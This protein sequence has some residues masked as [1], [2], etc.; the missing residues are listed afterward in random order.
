MCAQSYIAMGSSSFIVWLGAPEEHHIGAQWE[1]GL[2]SL[3]IVTREKLKYTFSMNK[4]KLVIHWDANT[5]PSQLLHFPRGFRRR[6]RV[7]TQKW[8][9]KKVEGARCSFTLPHRWGM[10]GPTPPLSIIVMLWWIPLPLEFGVAL[11]CATR[12]VSTSK[13]GIWSLGPRRISSS[14]YSHSS[15]IMTRRFP[16]RVTTFYWI[17]VIANLVLTP[18]FFIYIIKSDNKFFNIYFLFENMLKYYYLFFKIY[19][20]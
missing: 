16:K 1:W 3:V 14:C 8:K 18:L 17:S 15:S 7:P 10:V 5:C 13:N 4:I 12:L 20:L 9:D 6:W 11:S 19:F 2:A